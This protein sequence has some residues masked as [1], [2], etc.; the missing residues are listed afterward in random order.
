MLNNGDL[1]MDPI[2]S[3]K[4]TS[5]Y[6]VGRTFKHVRANNLTQARK[7]VNGGTKGIDDINAAY[8]AWVNVLKESKAGAV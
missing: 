1:A 6:M 2:N 4:V 5:V 7:S 8:N 3:Y